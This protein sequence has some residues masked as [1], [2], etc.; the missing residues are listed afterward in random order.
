LTKR[1]TVGMPV[2]HGTEHVA[3]ALR[4]LQQQTFRDF[5]AII[6][7]D[8]NDEAT[9]DVCRPFLADERFR[10]V[11]Q[12]ERLDWSG[13]F[14]WL[15]QQPMAEFFCYR[16]H[17]DTTAPEFFEVLLRTADARPDA[18]AV[19]CDCQWIGGRN[20][21]EIGP[22]IEG[23]V[24]SRLHQF[25]EQLQP[26]AIRGLIRRDAI[27]Q[28]GLVRLN[29]FRALCESSVW[30]AKVLRWGSF[31]RVPQPLYYRLDH[32]GNFYK[33]WVD[34]PEERKGRRGQR[35]SPECLKLQCRPAPPLRSDSIYSNSSWTVWWSFVRGRTG[36]TRRTLRKP[37]ANS[38]PLVFSV[39][40]MKE[41]CTFLVL[42]NC[43]PSSR[44]LLASR[45]CEMIT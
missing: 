31:I 39:L 16:Q 30:V 13:N 44:Y 38:S 41:T 15:L 43:H 18:A 26:V 36:Y 19:Y 40:R 10:M 23:D 45:I 33:H 1:I 27:Q 25:I 42:T 35:C 21:L 11:I 12:P 22:S 2:Y 37:A 9:A 3:E 5:E 24:L 17:D 28:A 34:W 14:N 4:S 32:S 29:E 20:D 8:G 6:S 7:I